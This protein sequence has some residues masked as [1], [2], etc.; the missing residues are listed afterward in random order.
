MKCSLKGNKL[1]F[2]EFFF[3]DLNKDTI[4]EYDLRKRTEIS[5]EEYREL[6]KRRAYSMAYFLLAKRD[7]P[8]RELYQKLVQKYREKDIIADLIAEFLDRGYLDDY[9][10]G[11]SYI[12]SH[13][14]GKKKMEFML[15]QKGLTREVISSLLEDNRERELEEI[16]RQWEKL[17]NKDRDKKIM[18]LMRKGFEYRDIQRAISDE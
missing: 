7:Y 12:A 6:I 4:L 18:S 14:Y 2:D 13:N 1:Y 10:Y 11:K 5:Y 15:F 9:E 16:K 8:S 17:G 3:I